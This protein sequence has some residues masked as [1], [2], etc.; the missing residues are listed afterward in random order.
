MNDSLKKVLKIAAVVAGLLLVAGIAIIFL[1]IKSNFSTQNNAGYGLEEALPAPSAKTYQLG[2]EAGMSAPMESTD[3]ASSEQA[4]G[5]TS[6][7]DK[8]VIKQGNLSLKVA[9]ADEAA[10]KVTEIAK[11]NKGDVASSNFYERTKGVKTGTITIKVA[12]SNFEKAFEEIKK[13][14]TQVVNESTNSQDVTEQYVDLQAQLKNKQAEEQSYLAILNRSGSV[15]DILKVT[16]ALARARGEIERL[17]ARIKY[18]DSQTEMS[19]ITANISEDVEVSPISGQWRPW[20]VAKSSVKALIVN[21]QGFIDWLIR[22]IIVG[23]PKLLLTAIILW[24]I[25]I[26]GRKVYRKLRK[27]DNPM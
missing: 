26:G 20:Q 6:E 5:E 17:Q 25:F 12:F 10:D 8:K 24:L 3:M 15:E 18:M 13:I 4:D 2:R 19:T 22:F 27:Q 16:Q 7:T 9:D 1:A 14:A 21:M 23:I 11:A